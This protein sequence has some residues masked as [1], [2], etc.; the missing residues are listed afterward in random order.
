M[1]R[2]LAVLFLLAASAAQ[3][4]PPPAPP[5]AVRSVALEL[6]R[7]FNARD[8]NAYS[9]LFAPDVR[10]YYGGRLMAPNKRAWIASV[11]RGFV[12]RVLRNKPLNIGLGEDTIIIF[13]LSSDNPKGPLTEE[14]AVLRAASYTLR[15]GKIVEVRFLGGASYLIDGKV[16]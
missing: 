16:G 3:A 10:V 9:R 1:R 11:A 5:E 4:A 15:G 12:S 13:E 6:T 8:L 2:F 14:I 7:A